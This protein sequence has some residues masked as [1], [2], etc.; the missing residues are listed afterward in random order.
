MPI[1]TCAKCAKP[2]TTFLCLE[3][4]NLAVPGGP[5]LIRLRRFGFNIP[6]YQ[7]KEMRLAAQV[8]GAIPIE[9]DTEDRSVLMA[10]R[11][12]ACDGKTYIGY[13]W[14]TQSG[15]S[16]SYSEAYPS[17]KNHASGRF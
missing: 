9:V 16:Y 10:H 6:Y 3:C 1:K 15:S 5:P 17:K 14:I 8:S 4:C 13:E 11:F 7:R 2:S 12:V